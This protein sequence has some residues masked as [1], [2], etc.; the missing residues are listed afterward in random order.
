MNQY[1]PRI[2]EPIP[3][4]ATPHHLMFISGDTACHVEFLMNEISA[5]KI[6][7]VLVNQTP[8]EPISLQLTPI[9]SIVG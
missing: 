3:L 9:D 6:P 1:H 7:H 2:R 5:P 8:D 4:Q